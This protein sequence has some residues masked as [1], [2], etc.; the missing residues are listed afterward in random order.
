MHYVLNYFEIISLIQHANA[1]RVLFI[2]R[3]AI[4]NCDDSI[5]DNSCF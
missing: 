5:A 3:A 2:L 1:L 4:N